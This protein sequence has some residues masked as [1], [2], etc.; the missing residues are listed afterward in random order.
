[1]L[2]IN[3]KYNSPNFSKYPNGKP[4]QT[5][6]K[7]VMLHS[8]VGNFAGALS[9]FQLTPDQRLKKFGKKSWSSAHILDDR[10]DRG[11]IHQLMDFS[12]RAWHGGGVTRRS[13]RAMKV[14][15]V[16]DPNN[17]CIGYEMTNYYDIN[18]DGKTSDLEK[19]PTE[20]EIEDF[21]DFMF[22]LEERSKTDPWIDI[23]ADAD[24]LLTHFDTNHYKPNM[25]KTY[26]QIVTMMLDRKNPMPE[27]KD[28]KDYHIN[29]IL[30]EIKRRLT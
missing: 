14:I 22:F 7:A 29:D 21:V 1:M 13:Q 17:S 10:K 5:V 26:E 15:G 8:T 4:K 12:Y 9:W 19:I 18:R 24:H 20:S 30:S 23:K 2:K 28:L 27:K 16:L 3:K 25:E 11:I 6:K